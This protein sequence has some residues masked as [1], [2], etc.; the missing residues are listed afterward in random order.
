MRLDRTLSAE[1]KAA[2][3]SDRAA[4]FDLLRRV[5]AARADLS[6]TKV[7]STFNDTLRKH[8]R[9][10]VAICIAAT[11]EA[12][13]ERLDYFGITWA[14]EVLSLLPGWTAGNKERGHIEDG[15]HPTAICDYARD[16]IK[17]TTE[18]GTL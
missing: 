11:L 16:F 9:V 17:Y 14:R 5:S 6:T 7:R 13:R 15:I 8:G 1:I 18:E 3:G 4:K 2:A 12:R 10:P